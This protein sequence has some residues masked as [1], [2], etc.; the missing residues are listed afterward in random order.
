MLNIRGS[1]LYYTAS[2]IVTH[3]GGRPVHR[4]RER[5]LQLR[6]C[7]SAYKSEKA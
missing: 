4:L 2:G 7:D 5:V 1:D 3:A 6:L